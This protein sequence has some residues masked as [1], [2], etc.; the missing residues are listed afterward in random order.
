MTDFIIRGSYAEITKELRREEEILGWKDAS[1]YHNCYLCLISK[2]HLNLEVHHLKSFS[3]ILNE[4]IEELYRKNVL[5]EKWFMSPYITTE[6]RDL[7]LNKHRKY[8]L[9]VVLHKKI[10]KEFHRLYG[11]DNTKVQFEVFKKSITE[12]RVNDLMAIPETGD[13]ICSQ[14]NKVVDILIGNI[15]LECEFI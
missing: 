9:G 4:T 2:K 12:E 5:D 11:H 3:S 7:F 14:C 15:C 8:G 1:L 6:I 13:V 10:H